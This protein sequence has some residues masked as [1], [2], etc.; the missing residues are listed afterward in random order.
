M[1]IDATYDSKSVGMIGDDFQAESSVFTDVLTRREESP[2]SPGIVANDTSVV[3]GDHELKAVLVKR[4]RLLALLQD[5][6]AE[7]TQLKEE[8]DHLDEGDC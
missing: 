6:E 4:V 2:S 3:V 8:L 7:L 1:S 5:R